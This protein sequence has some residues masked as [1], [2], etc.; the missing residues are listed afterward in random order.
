MSDTPNRKSKRV[1]GKR[2]KLSQMDIIGTEG[3]KKGFVR[4]VG[5]ASRSGEFAVEDVSIIDMGPPLRA[6][7]PGDSKPH[8]VSGIPLTDDDLRVINIFIQKHELEHR[9]LRNLKGQD[10]LEAYPKMYCVHPHKRPYESK[11]GVTIRMRFNCAGFVYEAYD[12]AEIRLFDSTS[13]PVVPLTFIDDAYPGMLRLIDKK[14]PFT[15]KDMGL[16]GE[17]P[18]PIMFCGYLFHGMDYLKA[19]SRLSK[20]KPAPGDEI[21]HESKS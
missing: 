19:G 18:W 7:P 10:L 2:V 13:L 5:L 6:F 1:E 17:G 8:F 15:L 21:I 12:Y 20:Y 11:P 3:R 16:E 4:H 9:T 14:K